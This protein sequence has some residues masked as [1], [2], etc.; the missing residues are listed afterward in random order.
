MIHGEEGKEEE[1]KGSEEIKRLKKGILGI[2]RMGHDGSK[3][4]KESK[5]DSEN[6]RK[7]EARTAGHD[8]GEDVFLGIV[9]EREKDDGIGYKADK[10]IGGKRWNR[11]IDGIR[12]AIQLRKDR[13][14]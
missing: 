12:K 2:D 4:G 7:K 14:Y 3:A 11:G 8:I 9:K 5:G 1:E 10:E 13:A 6:G